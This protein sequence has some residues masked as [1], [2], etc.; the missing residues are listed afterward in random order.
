MA[1]NIPPEQIVAQADSFVAMTHLA[2]GG[3]GLA[4][5][6]CCLGETQPELVQIEALKDRPTTGV[7]VAAHRDRARSHRIQAFLDFLS[8]SLT[9]DAPLLTGQAGNTSS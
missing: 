2:A 4:M 6:P 1:R 9:E 5:I 8:E 7:W 3:L